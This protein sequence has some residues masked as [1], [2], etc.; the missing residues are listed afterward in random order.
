MGL[1]LENTSIDRRNQSRMPRQ[2]LKE[3][4]RMSGASVILDLER[5]L[6]I[7]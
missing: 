4:T 7:T 6:P 1:T 5:V 2:T 3:S